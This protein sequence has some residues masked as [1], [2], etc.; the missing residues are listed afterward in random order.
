[1][2]EE[3]EN[4]DLKFYLDR[5]CEIPMSVLTLQFFKNFF[6]R[7]PNEHVFIL[8]YILLEKQVGLVDFVAEYGKISILPNET[9][10]ITAKL[11]D[12]AK[13]GLEP[14]RMKI[15]GYFEVLENEK[16]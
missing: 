6:I 10:K 2:T 1:M 15:K 7:N 3:N 14:D 12:L 5:N 8:Q 4:L 16:D 11:T 13:K 9:I